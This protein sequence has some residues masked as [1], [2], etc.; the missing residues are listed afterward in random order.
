MHEV[1]AVVDDSGL[2]HLAHEVVALARALAD[3]GE[4]R[5]AVVALGDIVDELL[6][7]HRLA[8]AGA[9]EEADLAAARVGLDKVDDLDAGLEHLDGCRE[10]VVARR[11][12]VD[13][14]RLGGLRLRQAVN[15][16]A[17]DVEQAAAHLRADGHRDGAARGHDGGAALEPVGG[18]H[19]DRAHAVL[20]KVLLHL[21]H[22]RR[23]AL[24][25]DL[26][27]VEDLGDG[28]GGE[29]AVDDGADDL[30]NGAGGADGGGG[31]DGGFHA[32]VCGS[33]AERR[34]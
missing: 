8:D 29:L 3:A 34:S 18:V 14:A 13:R 7:E 25:G 20:A 2:E 22:E 26:E 1:L 15:G 10:L 33:G 5:E 30:E 16:L 12:G 11:V 19:R 17:D 21:E 32:R 4:H 6:D 27:R 9:A 23:V 24:A 28:L 31:G